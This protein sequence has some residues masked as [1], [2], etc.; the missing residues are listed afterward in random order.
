M[1]QK[2]R[3]GYSKLNR[4]KAH[5]KALLRNL[6]NSLFIY[7][8]I[9]TTLRR[10]KEVKRVAEKLITKAKRGGLNNFRAV[11]SFL[12]NKDIV[13]KLFNDIAPRFV[14]RP[15]GYLRIVRFGAS[16]WEK[17]GYGLY[18]VNRLGDNA[19]RVL[20]SLVELKPQDEEMYLAGVGKRAR[21]EKEAL[22]KAK[23][24]AKKGQK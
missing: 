15:G 11:L 7:G 1:P 8:K 10:A 13:K 6:C 18:A 12:Q 14:N 22:I 2:H 4:S 19:P 5:R 16:R 9:T 20:L 17:E 3:F 21:M 24:K 23:R